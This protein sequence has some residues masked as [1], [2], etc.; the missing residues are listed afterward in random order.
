MNEIYDQPEFSQEDMLDQ[1]VERLAAGENLEAI[2][3]SFDPEADWLAPML[4]LV[5][6]VRGLR[7]AVPVPPA[8]ASLAALLAKA[9]RMAP[10]SPAGPPPRPWWE[11]LADSLRLPTGGIPRL[12]AIAASAALAVVVL[13]LGSALFLG[14]NTAAAQDV[15][16]GQ[17]LY[18]IKRLG[19]EMV[20]WL[21]QSNESRDARLMEYDERRRAEVHLLLDH[22][23]EAS[24]AFRGEVEALGTEQIV[25]SGIS[26]VIT[27]DTQVSGPIAVGAQVLTVARSVRDGTLIA[28][29]I[30]V[31]RPAQPTTTPSPTP[32]GTPSATPT[33]TPTASPSAT[34]TQEPTLTPEPTS[35]PVETPTP[36][37]TDKPE[38]TDT[39]VPTPSPTKEI[40]EPPEQ[41]DDG[42]GNANVDDGGRGD[43]ND[44]GNNNGD[45]GS[46]NDDN[47]NDNDSG[48]DDSS[49]D[50]NSD[51]GSNEDSENGEDGRDDDNGD[52]R[53]GD[54][55]NHDDTGEADDSDDH[56][57][58][59]GG[60]TMMIATE[61]RRIWPFD[62]VT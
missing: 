59:D 33:P 50:S 8:E 35:T 6:D 44:D 20:L 17:P 26:L 11:R 39:P 18:P 43:N 2:L 58:S 23:L 22:H 21:P 49:D 7:E 47:D 40:P 52:S 60:T 41:G 56:K 55:G 19:E 15:L 51:N 28:Q 53:S 42:D 61:A 16:P 12:A 9:E 25:V 27:D 57:G 62:H 36:A 14:T 4:A 32:T 3:A 24:V 10:T 30:V 38:P 45:D 48:H 46:S 1:A 37:P 34:P 5:S 31:T 13:T 29:N 54:I